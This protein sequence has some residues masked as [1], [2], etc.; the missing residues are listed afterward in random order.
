MAGQQSSDEVLAEIVQTEGRPETEPFLSLRK[1][2]KRFGQD[3]VLSEV[4][5]DCRPG[6]VRA[7]LGANGAGKSTLANIVLGVLR[8][9]GGQVLV[10]GRPVSFRNPHDASAAGIAAIYQELSVIEELNVAENTFLNREP[11]R[12][13]FIDRNRL[14]TDCAALLQRFGIDLDPEAPVSGLSMA[15]RQ[16]I[17]VV[18]AL[19][20]TTRLIIMD[21]PTASL[22]VEEQEKLFSIIH[23]LREEGISVLYVSHR[24]DEIFRIADTVTILRDGRVVASGS[25]ASMS[26]A[27][28]VGHIVGPARTPGAPGSRDGQ[29]PHGSASDPFLRVVGLRSDGRFGPVSLEI[30]PGEILAIT[31]LVGSGRSSLLRALFGS[32]RRVKGE[33]LVAGQRNRIRSVRRARRLG[34]G[35]VGEDRV[36]DG[37]AL[38]LSVLENLTSVHLPTWLGLY[39]PFLTRHMAKTGAARVLLGGSLSRNVRQLSGGNQQKVAFAKW[40]TGDLK[41][42]LCDEPTRGVDVGAR[43]EIHKLLRDTANQGVAVVVSSSDLDE[44]VA[45]ADR[46]VVMANGRIVME[47]KGAAIELS[48]LTGAVLGGP[49]SEQQSLWVGAEQAN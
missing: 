42:L 46:T 41:L 33:M 9:N 7:L 30:F 32:D 20:R 39:R 25:L 26:K 28:I 48:E 40:M 12:G 38:H 35:L 36:R 2:S 19:A 37:L 34:I 47:F 1:V 4:D 5:L 21:E 23:G 16:L 14:H 13:P 18:K 6:E 22:T 31:G 11:G 17:E 44:V 49:S 29:R 43:A 10:S 8:P 24:L 27:D 3:E 45:I 15:R